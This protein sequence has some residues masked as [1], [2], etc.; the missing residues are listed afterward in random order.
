MLKEEYLS[1][2]LKDDFSCQ[3]IA[4][5]IEHV[6]K[7]FPIAAEASAYP[8]RVI[9][10]MLA[11][12]AKYVTYEELVYFF[13][14]V[15][16]DRYSR[17]AL[18]R[19]VGSGN[20]ISE[21]F[22]VPGNYSRNA[23]TVSKDYFS[24]ACSYLPAKCHY[25]NKA[26]R[27]EGIVPMHLYM[28]GFNLMHLLRSP[29][30]FSWR[31]EY[32]LSLDKKK[33]GELMADV[34]AVIEAEHP[35][36]MYIEQ[37]MY[38]ERNSI[39]IGKLM[40][41]CNAGVN[42]D[43]GNVIVFSFAKTFSTIG[44]N[45]FMHPHFISTVISGMRMVG[46]DSLIA[47]YQMVVNDEI[48]PDSFCSPKIVSTFKDSLYH[49]LCFL[50]CINDND[51]T[52]R[53]S[54]DATLQPEYDMTLVELEEYIVSYKAM[55]NPYRTAYENTRRFQQAFNSFLSILH[56]EL[57]YLTSGR[58]Y[59][60]DV[61]LLLSGQPV[62]FVST[63]LLG[64]YFNLMCKD[65]YDTV[66]HLRTGLRNYYGKELSYVPSTNFFSPYA[67]NGRVKLRSCFKT[68][69]NGL[70][71]VCSGLDLSAVLQ[72]VFLSD[73]SEWVGVPFDFIHFVFVVDTEW[74]V[75]KLA[76]YIPCVSSSPYH[77]VSDRFRIFFM[78]SSELGCEDNLYGCFQF[79]AKKDAT[80]V[81]RHIEPKSK[82]VDRNDYT[83]KADF[84]RALLADE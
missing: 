21:K 8:H 5:F 83:N 77:S 16:S 68:A 1:M 33:K 3:N 22:K 40:N 34:V 45:S 66:S 58:L 41:Y 64:N 73:S 39:L 10:S 7:K 42:I 27:T 57:Q 78:K 14:P 43:D 53:G 9:Y 13:G 25:F 82:Q 31:Y 71:C 35:V 54:D 65:E 74:Q 62:Y 61:S 20:F 4:E 12:M 56:I 30:H 29:M 47:F 11:Y 79:G 17:I 28:A 76:G 67:A 50:G 72:S 63:H 51:S 48:K 75:A 26:R 18:Q 36:T 59:R 84:I 69:G 6:D 32:S 24:V 44:I 19:M 80:Y 15:F 23:Y 46:I 60:E 55:R 49:L 2:I 38:T 37:D 52:L 81:L 70:V